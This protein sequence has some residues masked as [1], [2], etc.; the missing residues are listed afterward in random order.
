MAIGPFVQKIGRFD[1]KVGEF[2]VKFYPWYERRIK[3]GN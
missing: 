3:N 2:N 1:I